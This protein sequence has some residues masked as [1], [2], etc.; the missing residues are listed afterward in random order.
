MFVAFLDPIFLQTTFQIK[1]RFS[2]Q[3]QLALLAAAIGASNVLANV[4]SHSFPIFVSDLRTVVHRKP[5]QSL[6]LRRAMDAFAN[7]VAPLSL[8]E[9]LR[10]RSTLKLELGS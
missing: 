6:Q 8:N 10:M 5:I 2:T 7:T 1:M 9:T 4:C 3:V